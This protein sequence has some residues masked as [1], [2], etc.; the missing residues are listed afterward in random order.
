MMRQPSSSLASSD[1]DDDL[2]LE[3]VEHCMKRKCMH[4][5][6]ANAYAYAGTAY[7]VLVVMLGLIG[8]FT[9][10]IVTTYSEN[11]PDFNSANFTIFTGL[12]ALITTA[13]TACHNG[14]GISKKECEHNCVSIAYSDIARNINTELELR[15]LQD[16]Q[17]K[18]IGAFIVFIKGCIDKADDSAPRL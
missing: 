8:G 17:F 16:S 5:A 14:M 7:I 11:D 4:T 15:D 10:I 2:L 6:R 13:L 1:P 12:I 18:S 9:N 3:W